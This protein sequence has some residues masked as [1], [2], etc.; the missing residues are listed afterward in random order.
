MSI[1]YTNS[2]GKANTSRLNGEYNY[3]ITK[4]GYDLLSS[5]VDINNSDV[6]I[7]ETLISQWLLQTGVW[8]DTG[9][10]SNDALWASI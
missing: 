2:E 8:N 6:N 10:W 4:E 7:D 1:I 3:S 9:I 5:S